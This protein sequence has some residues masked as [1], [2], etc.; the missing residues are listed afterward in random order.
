MIFR[1]ETFGPVA[2]LFRFKTE[3]EAIALA[4]DTEFGLAVVFLRPRRR[5]HLPRRRG[6]GIR[7]RRHQ[8]RHHLHRGGAVRRHEVIRP[9]PRGLEI[10]HRGLSGDQVPG[11]R[12][13]RHLSVA[14]DFDLFVIGGGS[15]GVRCARIA[16]GHGARVGIAEERFWGGTCVN[17][18][19]VPKKLLVHGRRIRRLR[20]RTRAA[21]AGT[22]RR[23]AHDWAALIATKDRE[24]A[25]LNGIYRQPAGRR[26]RAPSSRRARRFVDRAHAGCR[27]P[28]R[29][30]RAHRDRHRRPPGAR[31]TFP[32]PNSCI[33]S[34]DAFYLPSVPQRVIMLGGG[35]IAVEFAGIFAGLGRRGAIWCCASRCRCAASTR[36]CARPWPRRWR[37][38]ASRL[39]PGRTSRSRRPP[40][41]TARRVRLDDGTDDRTPTWCSP[42]SAACP[43]TDGLGLEQAGVATDGFGAVTV[44][45]EQRTSV[46]HIYAIGDVTDRLNLTP[47][48][49]A[50]GHALA[51]TP[52]RPGPA[53]MGAA[54]RWRPRCSPPRRSPPS[55]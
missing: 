26:R 53:P 8:R 37:R 22:S 47:V 49:I 46:P 32:A 20:R 35:Y 36:I 21:S 7:H 34:D 11:A 15:G 54:T 40:T 48:A 43:N 6:A 51:D 23:A 13:H 1:E 25:R 27:R 24:I 4:N 42:P 12:R 30:R 28:A 41:A 5:P 50:E 9:R 55:A 33:I 29:H 16:A 44:D 18:G 19:C 10:R 39:H 45:A 2:P 17:V 14:Y 38:R 31:R 3:E 52:V